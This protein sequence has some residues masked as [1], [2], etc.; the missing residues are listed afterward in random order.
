MW[1][2]SSPI[3]PMPSWP[4]PPTSIFQHS[5]VIRYIALSFIVALTGFDRRDF[6]VVNVS[7]VPSPE[8]RLRAIV[9]Y[10]YLHFRRQH[11]LSCLPFSDFLLLDLLTSSYIIRPRTSPPNVA[12]DRAFI[13]CL[14]P[15]KK[16][17]RTPASRKG[18]Q[19]GD[20][21]RAPTPL[22]WIVGF[23]VPARPAQVEQ[24]D[25]ALLVS[26]QKCQMGASPCTQSTGSSA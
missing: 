22:P 11:C 2:F 1:K 17:S 14:L 6:P 5:L 3:R 18:I 19:Q 16:P 25:S 26:P 21:L 12:H 4:P 9:P 8:A 10:Q 13:I 15:R 7:R 24:L 20:N 23:S